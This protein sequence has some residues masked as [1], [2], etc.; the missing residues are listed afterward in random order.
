MSTQETSEQEAKDVIEV[1]STHHM[2]SD[3]LYQL[4]P[5]EWRDLPTIPA[6]HAFNGEKR[7]VARFFSKRCVGDHPTQAEVMELMA[8]ILS[9]GK[10]V[11]SFMIPLAKVVIPAWKDGEGPTV[12]EFLENGADYSDAPKAC[13]IVSYPHLEVN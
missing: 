13:L 2:T 12:K 5:K 9:T 4:F 10:A 1:L 3:P 7:G 6:N 8:A 11:T